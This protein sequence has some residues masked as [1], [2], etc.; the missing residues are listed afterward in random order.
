MVEDVGGRVAVNDSWRGTIKGDGISFANCGI[1]LFIESVVL[2]SGPAFL[3][4]SGAG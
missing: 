2:A 1:S 3:G 4:S